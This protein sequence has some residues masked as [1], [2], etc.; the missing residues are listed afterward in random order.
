[1]P[2]PKIA[3]YSANFGNYRNELNYDIDNIYFDRNIDYYFFTDNQNLKSNKWRVIYHKLLPA[4]PFINSTRLTSKYLK[5]KQNGILKDYDYIIW[6]DSKSLKYLKFRLF[7]IDNL[8]KNDNSMFLIKHGGRLHAKE[9]II[10]TLQLGLEHPNALSFY[11]EIKDIEFKTVLANTTCIIYKNNNENLQ[12]LKTALETL[13]HK[14]MRRDQ[15]VFQYALYK[16][17]HEGKV[18][19]FNFPDLY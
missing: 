13:L 19:Y 14:G 7:K 4:L 9:E 2:L 1:M 8:F 15:N 11:H 12:V 18:G 17:N 10:T 3:I 6:I 16:N 5:F